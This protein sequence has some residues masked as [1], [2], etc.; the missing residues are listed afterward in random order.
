[1][2]ESDLQLGHQPPTKDK[3]RVTQVQFRQC[4]GTLKLAPTLCLCG[5]GQQQIGPDVARCCG[6]AVRGVNSSTGSSQP[7]TPAAATHPWLR[8]TPLLALIA[9]A[10]VLLLLAAGPGAANPIS[11]RVGHAQTSQAFQQ[12]SLE[13]QAHLQS[14]LAA[15]KLAWLHRPD[16]SSRQAAVAEFYRSIGD[17]L[18]WTAVGHATPQAI[19]I[20]GDLENAGAKGLDSAD[21]D[22]GEWASRIA[23]LQR[24]DKPAESELVEFDVGLTVSVM[25]YISDLHIGRVDPGLFHPGFDIEQNKYD[26]AR[27]LRDRIIRA[28]DLRPPL[29]EVEPPFPAYRRTVAALQEYETLAREYRGQPLPVPA[30]SVDPGASYSA[31]PQLARLLRLLGDLPANVEID[32]SATVYQG[33]LVAAVK[34]FQRRHGLEPDG[35][36]GRQTFQELNTPLAFRVEQLRLSLE[37]WR[38]LPHQFSQPP[39]VVNLPEF[40]LHAIDEQNRQVFAMNV[41]VGKAYGHQTPVFATT[42]RSVIFRPYW[43]VPLSIQTRELIPDIRR[44]PGYLAKHGYEVVDARRRVVSGG[45]VNQRILAGLRAGTFF[46]RQKPGPKNSLGLIKFDMPNPYD[47]YMHATPATEL[48]SKSRRDFSHGCIR[49]EDP[50]TLAEWVLRNN[51]GWTA[52]RILEAMNGNETFRVNL[53]KPIPVLIVYGTAVVSEKGEVQFCRD[54]YGL[55]AELEKALAERRP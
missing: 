26:L 21:Y 16:F 11:S 48:F 13:G 8:A 20:T 2:A 4:N 1:M 32:L 55:D 37:R 50:V 22:G 18:A 43:D 14:I 10:V 35:R 45:E 24:S 52:A 34:R 53:E 42:I 15:G 27:F 9:S 49:V 17:S 46:A 31:A 38:W 28:P 12:L 19:E 40:R 54:I 44:H 23:S 36:I 29:D 30:K 3:R 7:K 51:P 5:L 41:V 47:V 33:D 6:M 39:I 25:R